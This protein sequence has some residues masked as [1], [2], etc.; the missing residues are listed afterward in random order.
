MNRKQAIVAAALALAGSA[1]FA[2]TELQHFGATQPSATTRAEV[3]NEVLRARAAGEMLVSGEADVAGLFPK[4]QASTTS[5]ADVRA[6]VLK[7]RADGSLGR[8]REIDVQVG[9]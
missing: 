5:R 7:A 2:Q 6:A 9:H 3:R 8:Q 4:A 1:V